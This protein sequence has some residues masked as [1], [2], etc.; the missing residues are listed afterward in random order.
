MSF[1]PLHLHSQYSI[2]DALASVQ[3]IAT[4][5]AAQKL[6][7]V[8]LT[9]HGNLYGAIDFY[10]ACKNAGVKPI[11]GCEVYVAPGSRLDK[12]KVYG[13]KTAHHLAGNNGI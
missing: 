10:K 13:Q 1:V 11:I 6:P 9:D 8:A 5:A 7:A 12:T 4:A 3:D 2:L